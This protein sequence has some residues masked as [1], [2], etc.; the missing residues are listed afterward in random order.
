MYRVSPALWQ[1]N[2]AYIYICQNKKKRT[3]TIRQTNL[4]KIENWE[5]LPP[6]AEKCSARGV[7]GAPV[8]RW[9]SNAYPA[10]P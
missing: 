9:R 5:I 1:N 10:M 3:P 4:A 8:V 6:H 7:Y 2:L